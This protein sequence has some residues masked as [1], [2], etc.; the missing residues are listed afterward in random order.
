M[1]GWQFIGVGKP[2]TLNENIPD[3]HAGP[4]ELI[5]RTA[6]AGL[7]HSDLSYLDGTLSSLLGPAPIVLGHEFAGTVVEVGDVVT[8][9]ALGDRIAVNAKT[10]GPGTFIDGGFAD[11]VRIRDWEAVRIPNSVSWEQAAPATDAGRT[12]HHAVFSI[13]EVHEGSKL[14]IIGYGGL[15]GLAGA[16]AIAKGVTVMVADVNE[17]ARQH[18]LDDGAA[19]VVADIRELAD[20]RLDVI[21]DFAGF[22]VTTSGALKTIRH[23]GRVVQVGLARPQVTFDVQDL[24]LKE[25]QLFGSV[26]GENDDLASVLHFIETGTIR[27]RVETLPFESIGEGYERMLRGDYSGRLVATFDSEN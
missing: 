1:R 21:A 17:T 27:A 19:R 13:G 23:G 10:D 16:M 9:F 3:P 12:A 20:E 14:G 22:D 6:A 26:V 15:G 24:V 11:L 4:G 8:G 5:L 25:V 18:A 2:L 7:C